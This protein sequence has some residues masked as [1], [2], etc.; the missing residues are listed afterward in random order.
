M[1]D[2]QGVNQVKKRL[3]KQVTTMDNQLMRILKKAVDNGAS[4]IH[5]TTNKA[6]AFRIHGALVHLSKPI[7]TEDDTIRMTK[8]MLDGESWNMFQDEREWDFAVKLDGLSRFRMNLFYRQNTI[9]MAI[10]VISESIPNLEDLHMPEIL[11]RLTEA[12]RGMVLVTGPTGSGKSSTLAAMIKHIN[13]NKSQHIITLEDP[14]EYMHQNIKSL[15]DQREVGVD[16]PSFLTGLRSSLR[17]D[18]D[19]ILVGELRDIETMS[20]AL[21][22]AETGHLVFGT[23]HTSSAVSTVERIIGM[24]PPE[25]QEQVRTQ[26]SMSLNAVIAQQL[27]PTIDGKGRRALTEILISTGAVK[28]IIASNNTNQLSNAMQTGRKQGMH[29]M[30]MDARRLI[31]EGIID[32]D[33]V[34]SLLDPMDQESSEDLSNNKTVRRRK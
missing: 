19:V 28:N 22:A 10:R 6:P 24:F 11:E 14:I 12:K 1:S 7:L 5:I 31:Q 30:D 18:P 29:T 8:S 32:R 25:Q 34:K 3:N 33:S 23:L 16:T 13:T 26:L 15:I 20:T 21:T 2:S 17:Q 4:D 9:S 27:V